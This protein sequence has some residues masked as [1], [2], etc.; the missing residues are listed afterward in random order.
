MR[1]H[2]SDNYVKI[3]ANTKEAKDNKLS[4]RFMKKNR[5]NSQ[6]CWQ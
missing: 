3:S 5:K 1:T 6:S 4:M 2:A